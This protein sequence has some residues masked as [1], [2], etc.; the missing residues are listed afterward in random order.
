[1]YNHL[2]N[3]QLTQDNVNG[4]ACSRDTSKQNSP[5]F[6]HHPLKS[7][8]D[9]PNV[10]QVPVQKEN[11][12]DRFCRT[13]EWVKQQSK[14]SL[15]CPPTVQLPPQTPSTTSSS[16]V[17]PV[18]S[19]LPILTL[20]PPLPFQTNSEHLVDR[21]QPLI[22]NPL[23]LELAW[24]KEDIEAARVLCSLTSIETLRNYPF[25]VDSSPTLIGSKDPNVLIPQ[26]FLYDGTYSPSDLADKDDH[27]EVDDQVNNNKE[28]IDDAKTPKR[29]RS[30]DIGDVTHGDPFTEYRSTS[31]TSLNTLPPTPFDLSDSQWNEEVYDNGIVDALMLNK[32]LKMIEQ[33]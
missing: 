17:N 31:F 33:E 1:M 25:N 3:E 23:E 10:L 4:V 26:I 2:R 29:C 22:M 27:Q 32:K 21:S 8:P 7:F 13:W 24:T 18:S 12:H 6:A 15:S 16:T 9:F 20:P 14:Q 5:L 30:P 28:K 19:T 11:S